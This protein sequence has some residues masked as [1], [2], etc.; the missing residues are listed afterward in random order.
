[1]VFSSAAFFTVRLAVGKQLS[2]IVTVLSEGSEASVHLL[3]WVKLL[4]LTV[5]EVRAGQFLILN[6][7]LLLWLPKQFSSTTMLFNFFMS[8]KE[9]LLPCSKLRA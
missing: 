8:Q 1:M 4:F 5:M 9:R 3:K 7:P 2:Q 6:L